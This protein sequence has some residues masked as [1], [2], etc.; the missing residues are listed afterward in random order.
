MNRCYYC[1]KK[2]D[3]FGNLLGQA[4]IRPT[5]KCGEKKE[6]LFYIYNIQP[7]EGSE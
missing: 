2:V 5:C 6:P 1:G 7:Y 3:I 4:L